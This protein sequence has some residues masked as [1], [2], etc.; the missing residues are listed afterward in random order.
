MNTKS[1]FLV[2]ALIVISFAG[3][4]KSDSPVTPN[5]PQ[6][7]MPLAVGNYWIMVHSGFD[8][9]GNNNY[10]ESDTVNVTGKTTI[11]GETWYHFQESVMINRT[12]GVY[13][14]NSSSSES[15]LM[16]KYPANEGEKWTTKGTEFSLLS[17]NENIIV[18]AGTFSCHK[19]HYTD[20][21]IDY[22]GDMRIFNFTDWICPGKGL[23]KEEIYLQINSG[24]NFL[25]D[26][27][28]L[29]DYKL[30]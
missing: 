23:I 22:T 29:K 30:F 19:Y 4:N 26:I 17:K 3:C 9:L 7:L 24:G 25:I 12:D 20:S 21:S 1:I 27:L 15:L 16:Y 28:E 6:Y 10:S 11:N 8:S 14:Y 5:E 18:P 2:I 13:L